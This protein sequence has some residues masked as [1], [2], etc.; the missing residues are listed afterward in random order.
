M[1]EDLKPVHI[2]GTA[3]CQL[4]EN[5]LWDDERHCLFWTDITAGKIYRLNA[6]TELPETIYQ[7]DPVGGF[8]L[9]ENGD[10]LL[11]RVTDLVLLDSHGKISKVRDFSDQGM[12]RF[13]DVIADP[14]GRVFAGTIGKHPEAALYRMDSNGEITK[15]F[16]GT[17]CSNGMG[18]SPDQKKFYWTNTTTRQIFE[19]DFD[20]T[21]GGI[22]HRKIFYSATSEEGIPDGLTVDAEGCVWSARWGGSSLVRHASDGKVLGRIQFP[23][24]NISSLCFGGKNLDTLFV[25]AAKNA[26]DSN[27]HLRGLFRVQT[28]FRGATE[29]RSRI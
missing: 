5:P 15:L 19:F 22:S 25:T 7:G 26:N 3:E 17:G 13:N 21:S 23:S 29:F 8:T 20:A 18:F 24:V 4:S 14:R 9:Q 12:D 1:L 16:A 27:P 28:N 6:A 10:L 2:A 11:F